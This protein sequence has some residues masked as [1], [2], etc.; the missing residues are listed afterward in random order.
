MTDGLYFAKGEREHRLLLG[1]GNRHGLIAGATGT[2]KTVS[3]KVLAEGFSQAGVPVFVADVKGDIAGI[4]QP[5]A[6]NPKI[7]ARA[8]QLG[9]GALTYQGFPTVFWDLYG[10]QG[11]PVRA[12]VAEMGPL[13]LSRLLQ[14]NDTQEGVLN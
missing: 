8:K 14:L 11:P 6:A 2:G 7:E 3:L 13:L 9:L 10:K 1:L 4:S 12:T 5:G